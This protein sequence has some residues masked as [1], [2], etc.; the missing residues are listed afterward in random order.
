[1][2]FM[3]MSC[4]FHSRSARH[5]FDGK[6]EMAAITCEDPFRLLPDDLLRHVM[7]FL[8]DDDAPQTCVLDTR[9][10][11]LWR[12]VTSLDFDSYHY[13]SK[14]DK[15]KRFKQIVNLIIQLR[16]NSPLSKC[17]IT[18]YPDGAIMCLS[19]PST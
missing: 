15:C 3:T 18:Y 17:D 7:P 13:G 5:L 10:R 11:D 8:M 2:V 14:I 9:W 16:G 12:R 19:S 4:Y 6:L 1:M